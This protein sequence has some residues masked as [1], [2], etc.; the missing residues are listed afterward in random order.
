M[1]VLL[2]PNMILDHLLEREPFAK[3]SSKVI[4]CLQSQPFQGFIAW[5]NISN[6]YSMASMSANSGQA[7]EVLK[8][9]LKFLTVAP[10]SHEDLEA[11]FRFPIKN[12]EDAMQAAAAL[13]CKAEC[14]VTRKID[15]FQNSPVPAI[16]PGEFLSLFGR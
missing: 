11:A 10:V 8:D 15:D 1:K 3:D 2:D 13:A 5:H 9:L 12:F 7:K 4:E 6:I 16:L 14:M